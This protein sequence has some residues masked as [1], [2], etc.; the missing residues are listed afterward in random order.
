MDRL[1]VETDAPYLAPV[2]K[3]GKR[4]EPS[5]V[6]HTA[7]KLADIRGISVDELAL[8]TS[9]NFLRLFNRVPRD[10]VFRP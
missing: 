3:R 6:V 10:A 5:F 7:A 4:N 1:L 2:P 9:E 8:Q